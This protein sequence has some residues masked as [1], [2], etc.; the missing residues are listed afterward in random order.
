MHRALCISDFNYNDSCNHEYCFPKL[1]EYDSTLLDYILGMARM[2]DVSVTSRRL[3]EGKGGS[4]CH[5]QGQKK[6]EQ[7]CGDWNSLI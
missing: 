5:R 3:L 4:K 7:L 2:G 6:N 1:S